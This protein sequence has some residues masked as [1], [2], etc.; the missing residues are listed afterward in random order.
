MNILMLNPPFKRR[1]SRSSRSP[2][3]A[4]GGTIYYPLWLAYAT[5]VLEEAGFSVRLMDAPAEAWTVTDVL[6]RI[7]DFRPRLIVL[8]TSTPSIDNDVRVG[9][10]IKDRYP[11]SSLVLVGTHVSALPEETLRI[12]PKID[13]VARREY[14]YTLRDLAR[15]LEDG[16][17]FQTVLG[18]SFRERDG[19]VHNPDRPFIE[20]LDDL[21]FVPK[22]YKKHLNI[23][24]YFFAAAHHP[25]VMTI[26][27]RGCPHRCAFCLYPQTFH[28]RR[29]RRRSPENIVEEFEWVVHNLP[30]VKEIG[31]EDDTFTADRSRARKISGM[32]AEKNMKLKWFCNVRPDLD[33]DTLRLMKQ[34]G[35]RL[36]TVGFES[37]SQDM[38]DRMNKGLRLDGIRQFAD[39]ARK[40]KILVHGCIVIGYPGE[41]RET[42]QKSLDFARQLNCDSMQ[43]Y[44]L[45][46]YPGTEAFERAKADG[47]LA[48]GDYSKWVTEEGYHSC[49]LNLPGLSAEELLRISD[50]AVKSYHFRPAYIGMKL[51][52]SLVHPGEGRRTAKSALAYAKTL[53][54]SLAHR[55]PNPQKQFAS[56]AESGLERS[57]A[58][59]RG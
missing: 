16:H 17:S 51:K 36:V 35:C 47:H 33:L 58:E 10:T 26:T 24:S 42:I 59:R 23:E 45:Y 13:A 44:P 39:N 30:R 48:T 14:D 27:G 8:D 25:L 37:G 28:G 43:F 3:V 41:T 22:V 4:K 49:V 2:G 38:L 7:G 46:V 54:R 21:P 55:K 31:I 52:Q 18:L 40:A 9:M 32:L 34:A 15:A 12:H 5:G 19:I 56:A 20:N 6:D 57:A 53:W 11:G 29:Y 1:F 50:K